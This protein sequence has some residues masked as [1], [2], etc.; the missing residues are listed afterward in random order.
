MSWMGL[1]VLVREAVDGDLLPKLT[2]LVVL[3]YLG[4]VIWTLY[5]SEDGPEVICV[6]GVIGTD[7]DSCPHCKALFDQL[8]QQRR[9]MNGQPDHGHDS[10]NPSW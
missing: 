9:E 2:W 3:A 7:E 5:I 6:H 1:A 4:W 10:R 8:S